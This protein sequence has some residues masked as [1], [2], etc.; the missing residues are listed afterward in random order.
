M[1]N[2]MHNYDFMHITGLKVLP[3]RLEIAPHLSIVPYTGGSME[4]K[5]SLDEVL[6]YAKAQIKNFIRKKAYNL[7]REHQEE[8]EQECFLSIIKKYHDITADGGWRS[9]IYQK[10]NG[11]VLDYIKEGKGDEF[12]RSSVSKKGF[13]RANVYLNSN[14]EETDFSQFLGQQGHFTEAELDIKINWDLVSR[15]ASKD[16][17]L[18]VYAKH[19]LGHSLEQIALVFNKEHARIGQYVEEFVSRFDD[20][21]Y[22]D[23]A[24]FKQTCYAFGLCEKLGLPNVDQGSGWQLKPVDLNDLKPHA[25]ILEQQSQ[26]TMFMDD[27]N[28][29]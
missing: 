23:C 9:L 14:D 13:H 7:P 3:M 10:A 18:H 21:E 28:D 22:A 25:A 11:V 16:L 20:P 1:H 27:Q 24:W 2:L 15:L 12:S 26:M 5:P 4:E 6:D 29:A 19:L 8:I 17:M